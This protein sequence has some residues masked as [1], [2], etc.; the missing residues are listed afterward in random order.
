[1][2]VKDAFA[3]AEPYEQA[4]GA[5]SVQQGIFTTAELQGRLEWRL[6]RYRLFGKRMDK[7]QA[8]RMQ[9]QAL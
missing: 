8:T 5:A 2:N 9:K 1:M 3:A 4:S 7:A 6:I